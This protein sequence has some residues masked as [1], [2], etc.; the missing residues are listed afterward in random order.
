[1][2]R[3]TSECKNGTLDWEG[4]MQFRDTFE[5][6]HKA[7]YGFVGHYIGPSTSLA[8]RTSTTQA[9]WEGYQAG[10]AQATRELM[11]RSAA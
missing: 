2:N 7:K 8:Y 1:M 11:Q 4:G 6:W 10:A 5:R 3:K 9:R